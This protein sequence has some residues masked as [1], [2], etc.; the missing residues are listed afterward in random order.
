MPL[1][2]VGQHVLSSALA[3]AILNFVGLYDVFKEWHFLC[4]AGLFVMIFFSTC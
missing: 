3:Y 4:L 2:C 1:H